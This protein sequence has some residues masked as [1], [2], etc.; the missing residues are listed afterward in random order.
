MAIKVFFFFLFFICSFSHHAD[1]IFHLFELCG[2]PIREQQ[3]FWR[4]TQYVVKYAAKNFHQTLQFQQTLVHFIQNRQQN[5]LALTGYKTFVL[6]FDKNIY[7]IFLTESSHLL[8]LSRI[9]Y[10]SKDHWYFDQDLIF[11]PQVQDC[12]HLLRQSQVMPQ[13]KDVTLIK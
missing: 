4:K 11:T 5:R 13:E 6:G 9:F 1:T 7:M 3:P 2:W 10:L 8:F 12:P